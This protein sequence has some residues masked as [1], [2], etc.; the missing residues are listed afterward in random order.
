MDKF[1]CNTDPQNTISISNQ[2][3]VDLVMNKSSS[4]ATAKIL[5]K[6]ARPGNSKHQTPRKIIKVSPL[7]L[8]DIKEVESQ[9][10]IES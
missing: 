3:D 6:R 2:F 1:G 9:D 10:D 5:S 7:K 4:A 8:S